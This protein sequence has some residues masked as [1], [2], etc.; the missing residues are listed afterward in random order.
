MVKINLPSHFIPRLNSEEQKDIRQEIA[1]R[2]LDINIYKTTIDRTGHYNERKFATDRI[3]EAF[4]VIQNKA[5]ALCL[6]T[7]ERKTATLTSI[8]YSEFALLDDVRKYLDAN[9]K[10]Y[11]LLRRIVN[12]ASSLLY[13]FKKSDY[14]LFCDYMSQLKQSIA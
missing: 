12:Y 14:N 6:T 10:N 9:D 5:G 4:S 11:E 13:G 1:N 8:I 2:A 7:D 3:C